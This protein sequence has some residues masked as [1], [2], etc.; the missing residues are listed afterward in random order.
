MKKSIK[1]I[2]RVL[3]GFFLLIQLGFFQ[4]CSSLYIPPAINTPLFSEKGEFQ[5]GISVGQL[6]S[7]DINLSYSFTNNLG[8]IMNAN[9]C[10]YRS[11]L[12]NDYYRFYAGDI[13]LGYYR[14]FNRNMVF[15]A[16]G[17]YGV[18][19]IEGKDL[20]F[21]D[22]IK[23]PTNKFYFYPTFGHYSDFFDSAF[24]LRFISFSYNYSD[25]YRNDF[26]VEPIVTTKLGYKNIKFTVQIGYSFLM[27]NNPDLYYW[28]IITTVGGQINLSNKKYN[29][30]KNKPGF[31]K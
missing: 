6:Y 20:G 14:K 19:H 10:R 3:I 5:A 8:V 1:I 28:P 12:I 31:F 16:F 29:E 21:N 22:D 2:H 7:S 13:G 17:G 24:S 30:D 26:F 18:G 25:K 15:E 23:S 27:N 11:K 9:Y 4:S